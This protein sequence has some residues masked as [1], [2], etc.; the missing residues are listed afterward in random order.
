MGTSY[1]KTGKVKFFNQ[2]K[3]YGFLIDGT[4]LKEYFFHIS[5]T[6]S[7]VAKDD[8]VTFELRDG[9]RGIKAINVK[10]A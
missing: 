6:L 2:S 3:N 9:K 1:S 7:E 8:T 5:D 10:R 4:D